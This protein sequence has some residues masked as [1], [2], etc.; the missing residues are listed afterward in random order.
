MARFL[1]NRQT[2]QISKSIRGFTLIE[3][4]V[5]VAIAALGLIGVFGAVSQ[6]VGSSNRLRDRNLGHLDRRRPDNR[7]EIVRVLPRTFQ[8]F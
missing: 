6:I 1:W 4:L 7:I 5:A 8:V 2:M 3:V